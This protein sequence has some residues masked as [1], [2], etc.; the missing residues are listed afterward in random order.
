MQS[1]KHKK[2]AFLPFCTTEKLL[3][4]SRKTDKEA[5]AAIGAA[6]TSLFSRSV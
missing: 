3:R 5:T 2:G 6:E 4:F 1:I